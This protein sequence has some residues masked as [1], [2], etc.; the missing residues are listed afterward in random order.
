MLK[1]FRKQKSDPQEI[2]K[3]LFSDV[4][5]PSFP[6]AIMEVLATLRNP[7]STPEELMRKVECDPG[8]TVKVLRTVNSA[9]FGLSSKIEHIG[10]AVSLLGRARLEAV[11]LSIAVNKSFSGMKWGGFDYKAILAYRC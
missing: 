4:E 8:L 5:L 11:V 2:I 1:L 7:D 9:A 10:H 6:S 3:D